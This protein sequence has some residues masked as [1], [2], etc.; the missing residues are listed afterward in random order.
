MGKPSQQRR[1]RIRMTR[2]NIAK[3]CRESQELLSFKDKYI[4]VLQIEIVGLKVE[5][6]NLK[7]DY[8]HKEVEDTLRKENADLKAENCGIKLSLENIENSYKEK[9]SSLNDNFEREHN[10]IL[11]GHTEQ[12][13]IRLR[14]V[15]DQQSS[16]RTQLN[17]TQKRNNFLREQLDVLLDQNRIL[18]SKLT[19]LNQI[20]PS[21]SSPHPLDLR[22]ATSV[23]SNGKVSTDILTKNH[24]GQVATALLVDIS[25]PLVDI[26]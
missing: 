1:N 11:S 15:F 12:Y 4:E 20:V 14:E 5:I 22:K 25:T 2:Y 13:K 7:V 8:Q 3:A 26:T 18:S 21:K 19:S 9:I 17:E 10:Y 23:A 16:L 6:C 24:H